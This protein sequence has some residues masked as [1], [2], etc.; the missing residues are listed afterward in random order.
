[1]SLN[2]HISWPAAPLTA[3]LVHQ[4]LKSLPTSDILSKGL[5][6]STPLLQWSTYDDIDHELTHFHRKT[7]L[8]S[9]YIFRKALI[10]KHYL[11]RTIETY[12]KKHPGSVLTDASPRTFEVEISFADELDDMWTDELWELGRE[13]ESGTSWWILKPGMAD[14]GMGIRLFHSKEDLQKIFQSFEEGESDEEEDE[15]PEG[16]T[17]VVTSQLR[18]FVLQEYIMNPLLLDPSETLNRGT[19]LEDLIGRKFHLRVYCISSG[20]IQVYM[21]NRI[22]ALFSPAPYIDLSLGRS[23]DVDS[24]ELDLTPHLTNTSL[25]THFGDDN[26]RLFNDLEGCHILSGDST[27]KIQ[28]SDIDSLMTQIREVLADTFKAA[29]QSPVHFQALP[30]AFELFGVDFLISH[31]PSSRTRPF[32]INLLEINS[33]PAIELTGP[34]LTWI[35]EDLFESIAEVCVKPFFAQAESRETMETWEIG[36]VRH[37]FLK[38]MDEKVRGPS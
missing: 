10:R 13:L 5:Q 8:S 16:G 29:L 6:G 38:C 31:V 2:T 30:N 28:Q 15:L 18:H 22:L 9:S 14:R 20:D 35:L 32:Q 3:S 24:L 34:K 21:Y 4:A 36:E 11:T 23:Q 1:M 12:V 19:R 25:Q 37:N 26:V 27:M 17:G 7:V 33:E